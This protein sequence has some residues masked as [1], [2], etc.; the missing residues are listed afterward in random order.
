MN[1]RWLVLCDKHGVKTDPE[2][3]VY[4]EEI[5]KWESVPVWDSATRGT[6]KREA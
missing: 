4:D 6:Y 1:F 3:Q 2:L 5:E